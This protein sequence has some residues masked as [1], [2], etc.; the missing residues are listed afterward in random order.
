MEMM[1]DGLLSPLFTQ[2]E[3]LKERNILIDGIKA[4]QKSVSDIASQVGDKLFYGG[5]HPYGEFAT[6]Q[7]V[8]NITLE[9]VQNYYS[10]YAKPNNAYLTI[11]GDVDFNE[12]S[13]V[14]KAITPVPG[15]VGP[16]TIACLLSNTVECFIKSRS[17]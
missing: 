10:T 12:V 13:K 3:F 4:A 7:T 6:I 5:N 8:E 17:N 2:E 11:V 9:D 1:S 14:A 16:M 15:G